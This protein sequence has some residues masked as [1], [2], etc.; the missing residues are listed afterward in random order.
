MY[1][2][3][4]EVRQEIL[5]GLEKIEA[6]HRVKVIFACESGSRA[7]GFPSKNSDYDVRFIYAHPIDWYLTVDLEDKRDVI[8]LPIHDDLDISG[9]DLRKALKLFRKSNPPLLEWLGSPIVYWEKYTVA[10]NMRDLAPIAY[11]PISCMYHYFSMAKGNFRDY[12]RGDTVKLK[13]YF[14]VLRPLL[15]VIWL[16]RQLGVVPTEFQKLIEGTLEDDA[17]KE[18]IY[19]LIERKK[20]GEELDA[21]PR[22]PE[23]SSFIEREISRLEAEEFEKRAQK[24]PV[25]KLNTLFQDGLNEIW[26]H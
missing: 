9:W 18:A 6:E 22:I 14:Y 8:E 5:T 13:K 23:I 20:V 15:G 25:E 24:A 12:L 21:G 4:E 1:E 19:R 3:A 16:E 26:R 10:Q 11:S 17:L 7:W 2:I